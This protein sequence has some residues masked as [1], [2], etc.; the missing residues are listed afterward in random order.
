MLVIQHDNL[1]NV[2]NLIIPPTVKS[3]K[4]FGYLNLIERAL[5]LLKVF[6]VTS[7]AKDLSNLIKSLMNSVNS[8]LALIFLLF[9]ILA[10]FSLLG[11]QFFGGQFRNVFYS[12]M[13]FIIKNGLFSHK[14]SLSFYG[15]SYFEYS[16]GIF[17]QKLNKAIQMSQNHNKTL[18]LLFQHSS[19]YSSF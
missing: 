15:V 14:N 4:V 13:N 3:S 9:L 8:I 18:T 17:P 16:K 19:Q 11:M 7:Y 1:K 5:R 12:E 10:V 6:K 2:W